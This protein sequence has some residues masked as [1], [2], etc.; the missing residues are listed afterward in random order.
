MNSHLIVALVANAIGPTPPWV[1]EALDEAQ[2]KLLEIDCK[3]PAE[4]AAF[5]KDADVVWVMGGSLVVTAEILP[6]L[7]RCRF[8]LRTG[9]G[10]DNIPV[11]EANRLGISVA[12]TPEAVMHT[13]AEH[14]LGLLFAA[15][16]QIAVQDRLVHQGIWDRYRAMPQS[17]LLGST[18]GLVGFGRIAQQ[19]AK[20]TRGLAMRVLAFDDAVEANVFADLGV[21]KVSLD[22]LLTRS[23]FVSLHVPLTPN[24]RHLIGERELRLMKSSAILLNTARGPII[25]ETTL[26]RALSEGW[27]SA[28][29]LDVLEVE[30][31]SPDNPLLKLDNVVLTPHIA[32]CSDQLAEMFWRHSVQTLCAIAAGQP[33]L[34]QVDPESSPLPHK[35]KKGIMAFHEVSTEST[36]SS[37]IQVPS[38]AHSAIRTADPHGVSDPD[39]RRG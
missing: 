28:A 24:T 18:L 23:D 38:R 21:D 9:S 3:M 19:V 11:T 15:V 30:P 17:S 20:M 35:S 7:S 12:N 10:T 39:G 4:V 29:G 36:G 16:R 27:I 1:S 32:G 5:A 14:T 31:P 25:D 8:I 33:P 34:W 37:H 13:V 26:V 2:I 6:Q 22:E